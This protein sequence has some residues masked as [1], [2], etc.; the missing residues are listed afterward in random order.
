M[1]ILDVDALVLVSYIPLWVCFKSNKQNK[2][3]TL[4]V[5]IKFCNFRFYL[6]YSI[7]ID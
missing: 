1:L 2:F 6:D 5:Q 3:M 4:K 7:R